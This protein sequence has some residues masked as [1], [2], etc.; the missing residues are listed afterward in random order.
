ML[1]HLQKY[2]IR[3]IHN[4]FF[5][6]NFELT[7]NVTIYVT[8]CKEYVQYKNHETLFCKILTKT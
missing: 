5:A 2:G 7:Q 1:Y 6:W 4:H 8:M 3:V